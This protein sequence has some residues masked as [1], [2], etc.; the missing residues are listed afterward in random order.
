MQPFVSVVIPA[1]NAEDTIEACLRSAL[2][3]AWPADRLEVILVDN[4]ST[5]LTREKAKQL[6]CR[7]VIESKRGRSRARNR[8]VDAARGEFLAFLDADCE[9]PPDWVA[10]SVSLLQH[11]WTGAA[12]ARV[13][14][15]G[16]PLP[17]EHF[18]CAYYH[19]PFLDT[20]AL[21]ARRDAF[22]AALGF[23][24]EL[25]RNE[26]MDF[27]FRMLAT[28]FAF[29]WLPNVIV[30]KHHD[31]SHRELWHRGWDGGV[32]A[33]RLH[34]KWQT[35]VRRS[36]VGIYL[37]RFKLLARAIARDVAA[38]DYRAIRS[39][40]ETAKLISWLATYTQRPGVTR[41]ALKTATQLHRVLG[42]DRYLV[43]TQ[44]G[45]VLFDARR[46]TVEHLG[47][48]DVATIVTSMEEELAGCREPPRH[49]SWM[50]RR[51]AL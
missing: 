28:G 36:P 10:R 37:D 35:Y 23:D 33:A 31:L 39:T 11:S 19:L 7:V 41:A 14:R 50:R 3:Q 51:A 27:S 22:E 24:E 48:Q 9:A 29:G 8:G 43:L 2:A 5:D 6:G 44:N 26:D 20:C 38:K 16:Q 1:L 4:G 49:R 46:E 34:L 15:L 21:V 32:S 42:N 45:G 18:W 47:A 12:Q 40:E 17:S 25:G 13:Q 30:L